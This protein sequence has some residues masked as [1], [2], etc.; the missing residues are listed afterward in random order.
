MVWN[1]FSNLKSAC[2]EKTPIV[3]TVPEIVE[4]SSICPEIRDFICVENESEKRGL[5]FLE[6]Y[7]LIPKLKYSEAANL[8]TSIGKFIDL[9]YLFELEDLLQESIWWI[10]KNRF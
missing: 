3:F 6:G 9:H 10:Y 2:T 5:K 7:D 4:V 8:L 1:H